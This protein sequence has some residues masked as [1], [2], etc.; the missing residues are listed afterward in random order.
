MKDLEKRVKEL[1]IKLEKYSKSY[2]NTGESLVD[3]SVFDAMMQELREIENKFP[4]LVMENSPTRVIGYKSL[5]NNKIQRNWKMYSLDNVFNFKD[6]KKFFKD[7]SVDFFVE[8]KIDGISVSLV[9]RNGQFYSASTRGDGLVGEDITES[10]KNLS[11]VPKLIDILDSVEVRGEIFIP[12]DKFKKLNKELVSLGHETFANP[13]NIVS[14]SIRQKDNKVA[15]E[16]G[17]EVFAYSLIDVQSG[18]MLLDEQKENFRALKK[19]GFKTTEEVFLV[20]DYE[21]LFETIKWYE[22]NR[23]NLNYEIDGVVIKVN[24]TLVYEDIG[25]TAK[26]PK[27]AVAFKFRPELV[28]TKLLDIVPTVG[29][30]GKITYNAILEKVELTGS[31]ISAATLHN[32]NYIKELD[33]RVGDTVRIKKAGEV[34]PKVVSVNLSERK[35]GSAPWVEPTLCPSCQST[36]VPND[37]GKEVFCKNKNCPSQLVEFLNFFVSKKCFNIVGMS[38]SVIQKLMN[39]KLVYAPAD[40]FKLKD[41]KDT[42]LSLEKL[43]SKSVDNLLKAIEDSKVIRFS[44][45]LVSLGIPLVGSSFAEEIS[46]HSRSIDAFLEM[47]NNRD[48]VLKPN[49]Q[50]GR[51]LISYFENKENLKNLNHLFQLGIEVK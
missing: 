50:K 48:E 13:R 25:Y 22:K 44:K 46:S 39:A 18:K 29:R 7:H 30:T 49:S 45:L 21:E 33:L 36:L 41:K 4:D 10:V 2:Y 9:Y 40:I 37:L 43:S 31:Q 12:L 34:I 17:L 47:V 8:P 19:M 26:F 23:V 15:N 38:K 16:R 1:I 3:D 14:G 42:L 32:S 51:N 11:T 27:W 20:K 28:E 6:L 35:S 5:S 24:N